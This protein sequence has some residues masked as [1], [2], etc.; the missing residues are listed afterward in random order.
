MTN[1]HDPYKL[2]LTRIAM[3]KIITRLLAIFSES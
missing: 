3:I 2:G 1:K